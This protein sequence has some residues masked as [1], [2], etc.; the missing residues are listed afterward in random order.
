MALITRAGVVPVTVDEL[1]FV[2]TTKEAQEHLQKS[3]DIVIDIM[4]KDNNDQ[5]D[6]EIYLMTSKK[7][8][9]FY[10]FYL[11]LPTTALES[12][13]KKRNNKE[14]SIFNPEN[15]DNRT[16]RLKQEI[17]NWLHPFMY[18]KEDIES[19]FSPTCRNALKLNLSTCHELKNNY[20]PKIQR[21][22]R[23]RNEYI[24]VILDPLK[25]FH[26]MLTNIKERDTFWV[27]V[28]SDKI[29]KI[30]NGN[31][32]Y[33]VARIVRTS[34]NNKHRKHDPT[35]MMIREFSKKLNGGR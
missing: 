13:K 2:I 4:R 29:E 14:A 12:A 35:E 8:D 24:M 22:N 33:N 30:N 10:P 1:P 15:Y 7:S 3:L 11:F 9:R 26:H 28:N 16:A 5:E 34:K 31:Y 27:N 23:G 25:I 17:Y 6:V 20:L 21:Y 18:N 32:R 19:F